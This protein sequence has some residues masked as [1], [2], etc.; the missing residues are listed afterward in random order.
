MS[1]TLESK[2]KR[3][4]YLNFGLV[5]CAIAFDLFF[6]PLNI[7]IGDSGGIAVIFEKL[8]NVKPSITILV[9][10]LIMLL[11][12][13]L[14]LG[15][16]TTIN[17]IYATFAFPLYIELFKDIPRYITIDYSHLLLS[18]V[19]GAVI[20]GV[21]LGII[22]RNG[23]TTGGLDVLTQFMETKMGISI[24]TAGSIVNG[25]ILLFG[26]YVLGFTQT[27]YALI[28]IYI[29]GVV[30]DKVVLGIH[31]NKTLM[32]ITDKEEEIKEYIFEVLHYKTTIMD[33]KGGYSAENKKVVMCVVSTKDY[34][35]IKEGVLLIDNTAFMLVS[36][37]YEVRHRSRRII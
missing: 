7:V 27:F 9:V 11:I 37:A 36:D 5:L 35:K 8:M 19:V 34:F 3:F 21:G 33:G 16:E 24:G 26:I 6:D 2:I 31:D 28:I 12:S 1:K 22:Y 15:K 25:I 32:I 30:I 17:S 4:I 23:Y 14:F 18:C 29:I 20:S 13:L 10:Y